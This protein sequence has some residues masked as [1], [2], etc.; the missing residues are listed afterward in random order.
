ML[1]HIKNEG[2][3]VRH[4]VPLCDQLQKVRIINKISNTKGPR[5]MLEFCSSGQK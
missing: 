1:K 5:L 2:S 3:C 4:P